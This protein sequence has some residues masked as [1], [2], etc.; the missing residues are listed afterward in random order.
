M[1]KRLL[2]FIVIISSSTS[3]YAQ[4]DTTLLSGLRREQR[5][6][7]GLMS[8]DNIFIEK[9]QMMVGFSGSYSTHTNDN[10]SLVVIDNIVSNGYNFSVSSMFAYS[11]AANNAFGGRI[12]YN[13][14]LLRVDSS[15]IAFGEGDSGVNLAMDDC[16]LLSHSYSVM[17]ILRQYIP[18]GKNKRFA[19]FNEIQLE[20]GGSQSKY[21]YDLPVQGTYSTT[22]EFA[23]NFAP[24]VTAFASNHFAIEIN[25][26]AMG[27]SYSKTK[28]LHNQ[29]SEGDFTTN[30]F[31]FK[32][33]ILSIN[34]GVTYY[35]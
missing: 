21:T 19:L 25:V 7:R 27:F 23:I 5:A 12:S 6:V 28:E 14:D 3:L 8:L 13:R 17:V 22:T 11:F 20:G 33:N 10:Y 35:L 31:N 18:I 32:V 29:V 30:L 24:G 16:Y 9:G 2:I 15:V 1:L 4:E 26:G 34:L